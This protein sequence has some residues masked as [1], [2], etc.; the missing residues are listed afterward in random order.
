MLCYAARS[1][2]C[3]FCNRRSSF[4]FSTVILI[5]FPFPSLVAT[6][7]RFFASSMRSRPLLNL[8]FLQ[9]KQSNWL[10]A[11]SAIFAPR[12]FCLLRIAISLVA[13]E[14]NASARSLA[15]MIA[16][17]MLAAAAS[18]SSASKS[19]A[20]ASYRLLLPAPAL[21]LFQACR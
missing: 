1:S 2:V 19:A 11:S 7:I 3:I 13:N 14:G 17:Q 6:S 16:E 21:A 15:R 9:I 8:C 20:S 5:F 4:L 18:S 12:R 10:L